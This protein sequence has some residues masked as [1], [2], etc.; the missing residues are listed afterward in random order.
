MKATEGVSLRDRIFLSNLRS[1]IWLLEGDQ[2][3]GRQL[4]ASEEE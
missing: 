2:L 1:P 4:G 3:I